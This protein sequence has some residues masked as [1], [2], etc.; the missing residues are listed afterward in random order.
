MAAKRLIKYLINTAVL[1]LAIIF[2]IKVAGEFINQ[3]RSYGI[4]TAKYSY[5][6]YGAG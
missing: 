2:V 4:E 5:P 6:L 3:Y 1:S